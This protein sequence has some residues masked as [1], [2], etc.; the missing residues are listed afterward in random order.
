MT[1]S[2]L[3]AA[4]IYL[5]RRLLAIL[6][7]GFSS[8]LPLALTFGTLS[9]WMAEYGVSKTTIGLFALVGTPYTFKFLW[10]PFIDQM[11]LPFFTRLL[12]R[13]R[14]WMVVTQLALMGAIVG[15]GSTNPAENPGWT[16]I[17]ALL[18]AF[19]SASQDI[20]ID[21]Y[22][23]EILEERQYGAGPPWW[24][25]VTGSACWFLEPGRS[26]WPITPV[27]SSPTW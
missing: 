24:C 21:A 17:F 12:G 4:S 20:V 7:L 10:S 26:T 16:A 27:G 18:T 1:G 23:V 13:R 11:P 5:E 3:A 6:L 9:L 15:L 14:G 8:G 22:R 2:W 25:W 19:C